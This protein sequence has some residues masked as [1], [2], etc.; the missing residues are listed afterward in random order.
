MNT[1]TAG[2]KSFAQFNFDDLKYVTNNYDTPS[3]EEM[4]TK[5]IE[6]LSADEDGFFLM[7]EGA[8]IDKHSH[9]NDMENMMLSAEEFDK[10]VAAAL[11]FAEKDGETLVVVTGDHATGGMT[12]LSGSLPENRIRVNF[13]TTG[14]NG[15][16]LPVYA[17][18]PHSED[19]IGV[20]ENAELSQKI[21]NLIK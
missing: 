13:S 9:D 19:F 15:I 4:T 14:H 2:S 12:L 10:A 18:G 11:D 7:V 8:C 1:L 16:L 17:W 21:K 5:A 6:I 20:Y 3:I